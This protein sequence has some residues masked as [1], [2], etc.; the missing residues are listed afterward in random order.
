MGRELSR[1]YS[2]AA[3]RTKLPA[4]EARR[5]LADSEARLRVTFESPPVGIAHVA[6]GAGGLGSTKPQLNDLAVAVA[7][8]QQIRDGKSDR[9]GEDKRYLREHGTIVSGS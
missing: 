7:H 5:V 3:L 1:P 8:V 9:Y 2:A 4:G 6:P